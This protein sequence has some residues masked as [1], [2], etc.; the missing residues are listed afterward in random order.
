MFVQRGKTPRPIIWVHVKL[1]LESVLRDDV[2]ALS[3]RVK[4]RA[5]TQSAPPVRDLH[6]ARLFKKMIRKLSHLLS[7]L[8]QNPAGN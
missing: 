4:Q 6:S 8:C 3:V 1:N 5:A 7:R 2:V